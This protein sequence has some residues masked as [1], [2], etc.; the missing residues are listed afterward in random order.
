MG[1]WMRWQTEG[2]VT[3]RPNGRGCFPAG[4]RERQR[5]HQ[6]LPVRRGASQAAGIQAGLRQALRPPRHEGL[7]PHHPTPRGA[8]GG[9]EERRRRGKERKKKTDL[10]GPAAT[11]T[12]SNAFH[13]G[14]FLLLWVG[15]GGEGRGRGRG[16]G[17]RLTR[18]F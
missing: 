18:S 6:R 11:S 8:G 13:T 2:H 1:R 3:F 7:P 10:S 16:L 4:D 12:G 5:A 14:T 15:W 9:L 17:S